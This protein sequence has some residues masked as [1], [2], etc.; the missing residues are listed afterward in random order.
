MGGWQSVILILE[1]GE[2][3]HARTR[4]CGCC[5]GGA[6]DRT[7]MVVVLSCRGYAGLRTDEHG[8]V[9]YMA[10]RQ[11]IHDQLGRAGITDGFLLALPPESAARLLA[12]AIRI[13][14]PSGSVIYREDET[15]QLI[16]VVSG[17]LRVFLRAA[18]GRQVTVRYARTGD[19]A[20]LPLIV[21]GPAPLSIEAMTPASVVALRP[22]TLRSLLAEDPRVAMV[23]AEELTRQ[24]YRA[25]DDLSGQAFL[26][27][28]QRLARQ[29]LD[30][31]EPG[32]GH[33]LA[34]QANQQQLADAIGSVREVVTRALHQLRDEGL[35]DI[36]RH[37]IILTD[38]AAL[39]G[40]A[41]GGD[42]VAP[43]S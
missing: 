1:I 32:D 41:S 34:V 10:D 38:P 5:W 30:L 9:A 8:G 25:L 15:P 11:H 23:C 22:D 16:V 19:V 39:A 17:L 21:G 29:L 4:Y 6:W 12:E 40:R 18:D 13:D 14:V 31:A 7:A 27:V 33:S 28:G 2:L 37:E 3:G 20:G 36:G 35:I 24:L 26:T 43:K 42:A